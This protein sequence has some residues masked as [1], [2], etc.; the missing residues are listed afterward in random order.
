MSVQYKDLSGK[1]VVVTGGTSGLGFAMAQ[2]FACSGANVVVIGRSEQKMADVL[3]EIGPNVSGKAFNLNKVAEIPALVKELRETHGE[4]DVLVNNAGIN[5]K[6]EAEEVSDA[7]FDNIIL[8]NQKAVF[9]LT[10]EVARTM[11]PR[12]SG[13]IIMISSM[14][15]HYGLPFVLPYAASKAAVEGMTR[16]MAVE[17]APHGLRVNCVAPGF[18][19]TPMSTVA[20][21]SDPPRMNRVIVRTPMGRRGTPAEVADAVVFLASESAKFITGVV[22]P[23][24]G[25]NSIG[26]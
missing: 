12:K 13:S 20:L 8:T 3:P 21:E 16:T 5:L 23:V 11:I 22:L 10:R 14:A 7:E 19:A 6:K 26:F 9:S 24:D 4:I 18:I 17:W 15:A 2:A 25:G 1:V